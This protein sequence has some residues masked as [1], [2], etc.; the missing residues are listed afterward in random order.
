M[1]RR[2]IR[3]LPVTVGGVLIGILSDRDILVRA[4]LNE[5]GKLEVPNDPVSVGMTRDPET[6][7][8]DVPVSELA[9]RMIEMKIDALPVIG[10]H[11]RLLGLVTSTDLL[12]LL[13]NQTP[14]ARRLPFDFRLYHGEVVEELA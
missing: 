5:L 10:P 4:R 3:H 9:A 8:M 12:R 6:C 7:E 14:P 11:R 13:R 1:Q 2:R